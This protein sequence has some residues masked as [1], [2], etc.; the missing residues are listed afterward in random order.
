[1]EGVFDILP[2]CRILKIPL[3]RFPS[4]H[5]SSGSTP[6]QLSLSLKKKLLKNLCKGD[7]YTKRAQSQPSS[8]CSFIIISSL[9]Y[10][11]SQ[12]FQMGVDNMLKMITEIDQTA[13]GVMEEIGN[14]EILLLRGRKAW[15]K[16]RKG[17]RKLLMLY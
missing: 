13:C 17:F 2:S 15:R 3:Y 4:L 11:T 8:S 12:Q 5:A 7:Y 9:V 10:D 14:A 16:R 6:I 1:M